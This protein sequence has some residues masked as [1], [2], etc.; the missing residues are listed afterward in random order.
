VLAVAVYAL[1]HAPAKAALFLATLAASARS[2]DGQAGLHGAAASQRLSWLALVA[3]SVAAG[4]WVPA[5]LAPLGELPY[6]GGAVYVGAAAW[7]LLLGTLLA[8]VALFLARRYP[9]LTT[10]AVPAG[11]I[12]T[13]VERTLSAVK[14]HLRPAALPGVERPPRGPARA[15]LQLARGISARV[16]LLEHR[17]EAG[18]VFGL[19]LA[20]LVLLLFLALSGS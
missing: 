3:A 4:A 9:R 8:T 10:I 6:V 12:V 11:D 15:R 14:G 16:V 17:L 5:A 2:T 20:A 1:H 18:A 7:P 13:L 19:A